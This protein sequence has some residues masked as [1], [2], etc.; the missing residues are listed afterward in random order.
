MAS[1][2]FESQKI[3][4]PSLLARPADIVMPPAGLY[5]TDDFLFLNCRSIAPFILQRVYGSQSGLLR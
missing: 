2:P 3:K 1:P 5:F 4:D